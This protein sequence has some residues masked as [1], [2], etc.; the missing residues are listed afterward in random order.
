MR[1]DEAYLTPVEDVEIFGF[2]DYF[3]LKAAF[4]EFR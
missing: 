1:E 4:D 3:I 2:V